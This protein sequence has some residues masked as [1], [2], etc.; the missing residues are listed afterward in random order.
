M[1]V[2]IWRSFSCNNSSDFR[3]VARFTD[4]KTTNDV[5][6]ELTKF[7]NAHAKE[8]DAGLDEYLENDGGGEW[9]PAEPTRASTALG[10]K[11]GFK[12]RSS[13]HWGEDHLEGD[14]P[15]VVTS[16]T[17]LVLYHEY[18]GGFPNEIKK[19]LVARGASDV[20]R[21]AMSAPNVSVVFAI[22]PA[23]PA[24]KKLVKDLTKLFAQASDHEYI[25]QWKTQPAWTKGNDQP[26]AESVNTAFFSDAKTA[27]FYIPL[28][29]KQL[30]KLK[31]YL[32]KGGVKNPSIRLCEDGDLKKFKA[33]AAARCEGCDA[34]LEYLDARTHN[35]A[36]EQL[37]CAKCGGM[38]EL[39]TFLKKKPKKAAAKKK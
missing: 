5:A 4:T 39:D 14:E 7:L 9:P 24:A 21:A 31:S 23:A 25:Y 38:Y 17:T 19:Y 22:P 33:I 26:D 29:P 20:E 16:D 12:W 37:A 8:S 3:L 28:D 1:D 27:G 2:R 32:A 10:K 18:C 34:P 30:E 36:S 35:I 11:Y 15:I 13:F 6:K